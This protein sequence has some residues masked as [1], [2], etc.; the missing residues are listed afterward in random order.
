MSGTRTYVSPCHDVA[1]STL[2]R[3]GPRRTPP[4]GRRDAALDSIEELWD[5]RSAVPRGT[6]RRSRE[7]AGEHDAHPYRRST[8]GGGE[9]LFAP[10]RVGPWIPVTPVDLVP[11]QVR[12]LGASPAWASFRRHRR[13][14]DRGPVRN[15]ESDLRL[16]AAGRRTGQPCRTTRARSG[17]RVMCQKSVGR[18]SK[19]C[20]GL[21]VRSPHSFLITGSTKIKL[22]EH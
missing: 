22:N 9:E 10:H 7:A 21:V 3:C 15:D 6:T 5:R 19:A 4:R 13:G 18:K 2:V 8:F 20:R 12:R 16:H 1:A 17:R 14:T 11:S